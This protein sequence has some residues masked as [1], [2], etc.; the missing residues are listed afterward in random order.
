MADP[1][2]NKKSKKDIQALPLPPAAQAS[3]TPDWVSL[4]TQKEAES[5]QRAINH[6]KAMQ[7][8]HEQLYGAT[9]LR[10]KPNKN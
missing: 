8:V 7:K 1:F 6:D 5:V 9:G 4:I 3:K 2:A 10:S